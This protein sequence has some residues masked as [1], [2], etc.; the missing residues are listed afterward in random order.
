VGLLKDLRKTRDRIIEEE[1]AT[2]EN[3]TAKKRA[4]AKAK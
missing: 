1:L 4:G 3:R 2:L